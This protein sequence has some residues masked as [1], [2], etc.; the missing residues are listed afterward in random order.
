M[1]MA[2]RMPESAKKESARADPPAW[3]ELSLAPGASFIEMWIPC[4]LLRVCVALALAFGMPLAAAQAH[5]AKPVR[6]LVPFAAPE[7]RQRL[8][9][10]GIEAR[11]GTPGEL[12]RQLEADIAKWRR[13]IERASIARQA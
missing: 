10:L 6:I 3:L 9:D 12:R 5:P 7:M 2:A 13:V 4:V 11:A 8:H 1:I